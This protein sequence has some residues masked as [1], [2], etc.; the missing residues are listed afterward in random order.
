ML[1]GLVLVA[2]AL[3]CSAWVS[4]VSKDIVVSPLRAV[5]TKTEVPYLEKLDLSPA[6]SGYIEPSAPEVEEKEV[7]KKFSLLRK[8]PSE[9]KLWG[10]PSPEPTTGDYLSSLSKKKS[11]LFPTIFKK[12]QDYSM[13]G[14]LPTMPSKISYV[15]PVNPKPIDI[16]VPVQPL[17]VEPPE[18]EPAA[19]PPPPPTA[20]AVGDYLSSLS[21]SSSSTEVA[22]DYTFTR[23]SKEDYPP[24]KAL[25]EPPKASRR[26]SLSIPS[27][28]SVPTLP[29][30]SMPTLSLPNVSAPRI[31]VPSSIKSAA[32]YLQQQAPRSISVSPSL[33]NAASFLQK[34]S[35]VVVVDYSVTADFSSKPV[36]VITPKRN[37]ILK[38]ALLPV[39]GLRRA[40]GA[41]YRFISKGIHKV[42]RQPAF[43]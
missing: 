17:V 26:I 28:P 30:I 23:S 27:V 16:K 7:E 20:V 31:T 12:S 1:S 29:S 22:R 41:G 36:K 42:K 9:A 3:R 40:G 37:L 8:L 38:V 2:G 14:S 32:S 39:N 24:E 11:G 6:A 18:E 4:E 43:S 33:K 15:A 5:T 35:P 13:S 25:F 10:A 19:S 34:P 21:S